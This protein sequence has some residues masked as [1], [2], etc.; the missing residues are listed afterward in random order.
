MESVLAQAIDAVVTVLLFASVPV[1]WYLVRCHKL[2]GLGERLGLYAPRRWDWKS[3]ARWVGGA[4]IAA[5]AINVL[6][7][8]SGRS[9][10]GVAELDTLSG[11]ELLVILFLYGIR[12]GVSEEL[13]FRGLIARGAFNRLGFSTGNIVQAL[14]FAFPHVIADDRLNTMD[15]VMRVAIAGALGWVFG[16][17]THKK[18]QGSILP[19]MAAHVAM[20]ML[21]SWAMI[22]AVPA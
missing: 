15:T 20:N 7:W 21:L 17:V 18:A 3:A 2:A 13:F 9:A 1:A 8:R 4:G 22:V 5:L 10:R 14:V 16:Y 11:I 12:T 6:L 19:V